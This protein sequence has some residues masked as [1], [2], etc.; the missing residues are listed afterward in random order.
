MVYCCSQIVSIVC[1]ERNVLF[2]TFFAI[3]AVWNSAE[4]AFDIKLVSEYSGI[5]TNLPIMKLSENIELICELC[6][7]KRIEHILPL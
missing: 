6:T 4:K 2:K 5:A 3:L 1:K 7:M